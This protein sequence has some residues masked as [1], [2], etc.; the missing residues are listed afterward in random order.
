MGWLPGEKDADGQ[1]RWLAF[2]D[3]THLLTLSTADKLTLWE[4]PACRAVYTTSIRNTPALSPGRKYLTVFTGGNA[5][6]LL[7]TTGE[8]SGK[9]AGP[10]LSNLRALVYRRDGTELVGLDGASTLI[11]W[12]ATTGERKDEYQPV[13]LPATTLE[14]YGTDS[15]LLGDTLYNL[16]VKWPLSTLTPAGNA[17]HAS[18]SPDGR[19]WFTHASAPNDAPVLSAHTLPSAVMQ[20]TVKQVAAGQISSVLPPD[21]VVTVRVE[22]AGPAT[23]PD[24]FRTALGDLIAS[25]LQQ[26]GFKVGPQGTA[27]LVVKLGQRE[28]GEVRKQLVTVPR[29]GMVEVKVFEVVIDT[30]L[31]DT[32]GTVLWSQKASLQTPTV[33]GALRTEDAQA[34]LNKNLWATVSPKATG[35]VPARGMVRTPTGTEA[36]P[37]RVTLTGDR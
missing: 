23:D 31:L 17:V 13:A 28:T 34:T 15:V 27:T 26:D 8:R 11:R 29:R 16:A 21:A 10:N 33:P 6:V 20:E 37:P 18:G 19:Y 22:G 3:S 9:L 25:R 4:I 5:E 7:A 32:K 1:V 36:W 14:W 12:D 2:V 24:G 30:K 35:M